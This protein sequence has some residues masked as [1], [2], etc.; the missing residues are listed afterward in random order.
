MR[1]LTRLAA[2][3]AICSSCIGAVSAQRSRADELIQIDVPALTISAG[4]HSFIDLIDD[5]L[6]QQG[7][8]AGLVGQAAY[9]ANLTYLGIANALTLDV[10]NFGQ[11]AVLSIPSTGHSQAFTATSPSDL[12][13]QI[14]DYIKRDGAVEWARFLEE[15]NARSALSII[16]GNPRAATALLAGSAFRRFGIDTSR[17]RIGYQSGEL[18]DWGGFQLRVEGSGYGAVDVPNFDNL[19]TWDGVLTLAGMGR[20][21][22]FSF[23]AIGQYLDYDNADS[24]EVGLELGLPILLR[25]TDGDEVLPLVWQ[26]TPFFQSGAGASVD[27]AAGGLFVGG[28]AVSSAALELGPIEVTLANELAYY[29]GIPVNNIKG[30]DFETEL[31][32]L[33]IKNGVKGAI[34]LLDMLFADASVTLTDFALGNAAVDDYVTPS[35]GAGV[36]LGGIATLRIGYEGDFDASGGD[37]EA[38]SLRATIDLQ[39]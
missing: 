38:H 9:T 4:S 36:I 24:Y 10:T 31:S 3:L 12:E 26:V 19:E 28:G 33:V 34:H 25:K 21:V 17:A 5:F 18:S 7:L 20:T 35:V 8:F 29:H 23:S 39:F 22:G 1:S 11:N 30:Y 32:Q 14:E 15:V 13:N 27:L 2:G 16:D 6:N 37:Y